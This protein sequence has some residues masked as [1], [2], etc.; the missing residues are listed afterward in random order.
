MAVY[1]IIK[2]SQL[3]SAHRFD[4]EYFQPEYL[5]AEK[6]LNSIKT[7]SLENLAESILSFGAYSLTSNIEWKKDGIPYVNVGDIHNGYIDYSN[8]KFIS[9]EVDKILKKSQLRK[10]YCTDYGWYNRECRCSS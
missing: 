2:K 5:E 9:E 3:E 10:R 6:K 7:E 8:V 1:S 4:A